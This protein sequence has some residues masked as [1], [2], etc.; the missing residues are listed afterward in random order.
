MTELIVHV[1]KLGLPKSDI[2]LPFM[3]ELILHVDKFGLPK[4]TRPHCYNTQ[5]ASLIPPVRHQTALHDKNS[6]Y[7]W[8][9][10]DFLRHQT[11]LH[12]KKPST[13]GA[14]LYNQ[15]PAFFKQLTGKT[16]KSKLDSWLLEHA[17]YTVQEFSEKIS[18]TLH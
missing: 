17:I 3:T 6:F 12:D 9:S 7:M 1:D 4:V 18:Q 16:M 8:T 11:A 13:M 15:L 5:N 14:P 2:K 10:L